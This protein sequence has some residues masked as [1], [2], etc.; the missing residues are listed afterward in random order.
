MQ[1]KFKQSFNQLF[2]GCRTCGRRPQTH[3]LLTDIPL[4]ELSAAGARAF[5]RRHWRQRSAGMNQRC[6]S[7]RSTSTVVQSRSDGRSLSVS[8]SLL[9]DV[10]TRRRSARRR[11]PVHAG[12][13]IAE[14]NDYDLIWN[15][16]KRRF[17]VDSK[18]LCV[19]DEDIDL[20]RPDCRLS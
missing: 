9:S 20:H 4:Q 15:L 1:E 7:T 16:R 3:T 13:S 14:W 12:W 5:D 17:H 6:N 19:R 2:I 11:L 18:V 10:T 8:S